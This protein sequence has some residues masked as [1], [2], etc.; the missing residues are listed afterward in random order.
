M[1]H[2]L[3]RIKDREY[4]LS[5]HKSFDEFV[6][7]E[8]EMNKAHANRLIQAALIATTLAPT[9]I[10]PTSE[11]QVR[12]L[13]KL[14][15]AQQIE[16]WTEANEKARTDKDGK[17]IVTGDDVLRVVN[18]KVPKKKKRAPKPIRVR[19]PLATV[20]IE[21]RKDGHDA[22]KALLDALAKIRARKSKAA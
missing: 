18:T 4:Y 15:P 3:A 11:R 8:Y 14:K 5:T 1:G 7:D 13:S 22:E 16:A 21:F 20:V 17:P 6:Q 2:A 12:P 9:G 19:V 10:Q